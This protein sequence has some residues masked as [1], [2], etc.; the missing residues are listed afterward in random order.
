MGQSCTFQISQ[1]RHA[2]FA[3]PIPGAAFCSWLRL[4]PAVRHPTTT[5]GALKSGCVAHSIA[6]LYLSI[7]M[8]AQTCFSITKTTRSA[9]LESISHVPWAYRSV[10]RLIVDAPLSPAHRPA[11]SCKLCPGCASRPISPIG[12]AF[13]NPCCPINRRISQPHRHAPTTSMPALGSARDHKYPIRW[14]GNSPCYEIYILVGGKT[15][16]RSGGARTAPT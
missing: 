1:K 5:A 13:T 4:S 16:P 7:A 11:D 8:L 15:L 10:L 3:G 6:S 14:R 2:I 12:C 9:N